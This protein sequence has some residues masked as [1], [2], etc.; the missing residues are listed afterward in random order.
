MTQYLV[1]GGAGFIGSHLVEALLKEPDTTRVRVFDNLSTGRL[2]NLAGVEANIEFIEGD[3]NQQEA[4]AEATQEIDIVYH[5]AAQVSVP[6]SVE[7]PLTT[8][9]INTV[10]AL[11][12]LEAARANR[13]KRLVF[14]STC[15]LYGDEPTLPKQETMPLFPLSPYAVSKLAAEGYCLNYMAH[16]GL[17][18]VILRYF[19][20]YGPRQQPSS[21]YAGV[22]SRFIDRLLAEK[23]VTIYGDGEQARDFVYVTDVARANLLAGQSR[24]AIG[25]I[26]NIGAGLPTTI[27]ALYQTVSGLLEVNLPPQYGPPRAGDVRLSYADT[28]L[29]QHHLGW[30][31]DVSLANGL[32]QTISTML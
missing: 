29:A 23:P 17:E 11:N 9:E 27:N 1:T 10:G 16:Y 19:N 26:L 20:V 2:D 5:L 6:L 4:L 14:S 22:I 30:Q 21:A 28:R 15:A 8:N 32:A 18:T 31:A 7:D 3:L 12:L 13:V 24:S 25:H